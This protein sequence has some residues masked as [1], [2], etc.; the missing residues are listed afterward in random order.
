M[1]LILFKLTPT[2]FTNNTTKQYLLKILLKYQLGK[3]TSKVNTKVLDSLS[4]A[5]VY[6]AISFEVFLDFSF[7]EIMHNKHMNV[8]YGLLEW[9]ANKY[10]MQSVNNEFDFLSMAK[11]CG[12]N[13]SID[14]NYNTDGLGGK[15]RTNMGG[16]ERVNGML[17]KR[18]A[19]IKAGEKN[20]KMKKK[21]E[22]FVEKLR[23]N[24][25]DSMMRQSTTTPT[26]MGK[27]KK[28]DLSKEVDGRPVTGNQGK[29]PNV[30]T[31]QE[32]FDVGQSQNFPKTNEN[33]HQKPRNHP[34]SQ[35]S[36]HTE[37]PEHLKD[38]LTEKPSTSGNRTPNKRVR[39]SSTHDFTN[40]SFEYSRDDDESI[41]QNY[42][43]ASTQNA[44]PQSLPDLNPPQSPY[45]HPHTALQPHE[46]D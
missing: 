5:L 26:K 35:K 28:S 39:N 8:R 15:G 42:N 31:S 22:Y 43:Q 2:A 30:R 7:K 23:E 38:Y 46:F 20:I 14:M 4:K 3:T 33:S 18:L 6:R 12:I 29:I 25:A 10:P 17:F 32:N 9:I 24:L 21:I 37:G 40:N 27:R 13:D 36:K 11:K 16:L 41:L 19:E 44:P 45:H 34:S 1:L